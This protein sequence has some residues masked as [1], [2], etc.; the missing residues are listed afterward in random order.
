MK[1]LCD[2]SRL[3][4]GLLKPHNRS[5]IRNMLRQHAQSNLFVKNIHCS[6]SRIK[7][8]QK[9]GSIRLIYNLSD[10]TKLF[11]EGCNSQEIKVVQQASKRMKISK[12][13]DYGP[14]PPST[15]IQT[16]ERVG[17]KLKHK[18]VTIKG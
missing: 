9:L 11:E 10:K 2:Q 18:K 16:A 14:E 1:D 15:A 3:K 13:R 17:L 8:K 7:M 12:R 4:T 6:P 5:D